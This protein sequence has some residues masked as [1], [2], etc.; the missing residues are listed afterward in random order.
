MTLI[1]SFIPLVSYNKSIFDVK[2]QIEKTNIELSETI[3]MGDLDPS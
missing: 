1:S 2:V 3:Y